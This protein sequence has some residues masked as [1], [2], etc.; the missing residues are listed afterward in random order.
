MKKSGA[1]AIVAVFLWLTIP[2][3]AAGVRIHVIAAGDGDAILIEARNKTTR[4]ALVDTG[5]Y[6]AGFEVSRYL[7]SRG[8][9]RL[10]ALILTHPHKDHIGGSFLIARRF[11][12]RAFFDNGE[13]LAGSR[14]AL[15]LH[16]R[17]EETIRRSP[18][19]QTLSRGDTLALGPARLRVLWPRQGRLTDNWNANSLVIMLE[20]GSF[21]ALLAGD[22]IADAEQE[23]MKVETDLAANVLKVGHH[24]ARDTAGARFLARVGASLAVISVDETKQRGYPSEETLNRIGRAGARILRT[25][26]HGS[27]VITARETGAFSV[28]LVKK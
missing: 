5:S 21:R 23:L 1:L 25:D 12:P 3:L 8:I 9:R 10:D 19:Y 24:A 6:T 2:A 15:A 14:Y 22:L 27:I 18:N 16:R 20:Y 28:H 17:Y 11:G 7:A 26:R 13:P 4:R